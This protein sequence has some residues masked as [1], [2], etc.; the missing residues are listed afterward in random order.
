MNVS[1][2]YLQVVVLE[3]LYK[4]ISEVWD[5]HALLNAMDE[6]DGI[7]MSTNIIEEASD[8]CWGV[9]S[10]QIET[11]EYHESEEIKQMTGRGL[12]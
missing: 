3:D 2:S 4:R 8:E 11:K 7:H 9:K 6:Q 5:L 10:R 1:T 12:E